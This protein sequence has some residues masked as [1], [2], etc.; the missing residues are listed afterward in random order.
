MK[1]SYR[2]IL[3][4]GLFVV[5][6]GGLVFALTGCGFF[7]KAP[8][9][10]ITTE[11]EATDGTVTVNVGDP[12]KFDGSDSADPDGDIVAYDWNFGATEDNFTLAA[13]NVTAS[14]EVQSGSY[15]AAD[16]YTVTLKVTD[17][18]GAAAEDSVEVKVE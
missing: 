2:R 17:D 6:I 16:T 10:N 8:T 3:S 5:L 4:V 7:N 9:A 11:P 18:G 12:I 13:S 15:N 14:G 1:K